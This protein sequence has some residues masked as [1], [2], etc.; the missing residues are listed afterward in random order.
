MAELKHH[1]KQENKTV[2]ALTAHVI[3]VL[4]ENNL[5]HDEI[6]IQNMTRKIKM[7]PGEDHPLYDKISCCR[8]HSRPVSDVGKNHSKRLEDP[9]TI[10]SH[11]N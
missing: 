6:V 8:Y 5:E 1:T 7:E 3:A 11:Y 10:R 9:K 4:D 2:T